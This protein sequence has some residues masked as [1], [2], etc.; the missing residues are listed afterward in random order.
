MKKLFILLLIICS[1]KK[2]EDRKCWKFSGNSMET[3]VSLENF[4]ELEIRS[5]LI[6]NL[7]QDSINYAIIKGGENVVGLVSADIQQ[8]KLILNNNNKCNYLRDGKKKI[9][10]DVHFV[11]VK[12]IIYYGSETL[13]SVGKIIAP[14][15]AVDIKETSGTVYLEVDAQE[16][17]LSAEPSWANFVLSG[18]AKMARLSIKGNAYGDARGLKV[19]DKLLCSS[20]TAGN[21]YVNGDVSLLKCETLGSGNVYYTNSPGNI[22]WNDYSKG[23]LLQTP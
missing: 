19:H 10:V 15:L 2:A 21:I 16:F 11:S 17:S 12:K 7:I 18:F 9:T 6:V 23:K 8:G 14:I 5:H 13:K 3:K 4:D 20:R 22:E 1:C